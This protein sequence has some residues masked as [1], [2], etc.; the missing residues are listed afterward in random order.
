M[1]RIPAC[2]STGCWDC[3]TS[4]S[5]MTHRFRQRSAS[6]AAAQHASQKDRKWPTPW[7]E[8][9]RLALS[10]EFSGLKHWAFERPAVLSPVHV[11]LGFKI[12]LRPLGL[13]S[14]ALRATPPPQRPP[15]QG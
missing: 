12:F 9:G 15:G 4:C 2:Y 14:M 13:A 5:F 7:N 6:T 1:S 11:C 3:I 10:E 8:G